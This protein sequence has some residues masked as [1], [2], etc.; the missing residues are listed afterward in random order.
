MENAIAQIFTLHV[1]RA[2]RDYCVSLWNTY[3]FRLKLRNK[4]ISKVGDFSAS[5]G[6]IPL[7]TINRDLHPYLFLITYIHEVAHLVA[8]EKF[9]NRIESHGKEWKSLFNQLMQPVL[10]EEIF[11]SPLLVVLKKHLTNP[12]ASTFSDMALSKI[13]RHYDSKQKNVVL[14]SQLPEGTV[15]GYNGKWFKRGKMRRTR[16]VCNE[17]GSRHKYLV[18]ADAAVNHAQPTLL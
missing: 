3:N 11:P 13:L 18:P 17:L 1:P 8:H 4:R 9:G 14:L 12:K 16:I 10:L 2:S 7:I 15:F 6:T 5:P